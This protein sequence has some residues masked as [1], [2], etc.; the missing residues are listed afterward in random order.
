MNLFEA[1][2]QASDTPGSVD[3]PSAAQLDRDDPLRPRRKAF[4][5]PDG[6]IYLDGNSLGPMT[7]AARQR[8]HDVVEQQWG[9]GLITSWNR[10]AWI[11]L[12][13]TVGEKI[14]PLLGAGTGQVICCDSISVNLFKLLSAALRLNPGRRKVLSQRD[15]FPTD[16]YVGQG[17]QELLGTQRC[18]LVT[19]DEGDIESAL[20]Q[21]VAVLMLSQVNFR[22]GY[23]H[24][25]QRLTE[26][27]HARG[28]LVIWDLAHSAGIMPLELDR[29]QV[30]FAVGCGYKYLN[31][32]PGAPAFIYAARRHQHALQQPLAGWMGH[33]APFSF[34]PEYE[35]ANDIKQ[36][37]AGTPPVLS[38]SVLDAALETYRELPVEL[39]REKSL[40]LADYFAI[41]V[42]QCREQDSLRR[43]TP[44]DH[45]QRGGQ[46]A[47]T[48]EHAYAIC[49]ALIAAGV[50]ADF[51][52]PNI[53]R[54][55][56]SPLYLSYTEMD[57]AVVRLLAIMRRGT[58]RRP[59]Y[60]RKEKVT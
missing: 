12:P 42:L 14:A 46:L 24:D 18:E 25:I 20:D 15:N 55:G 5:L 31:G 38:M 10:H 60:N 32:G 49:Q 48:H 47:Y 56:F 17:L 39:V 59:E 3:L 16:L 27:A 13:E 22:S 58:Y 52:A 11:D 7:A 8:A 45:R 30:D 54:F 41:R 26:L 1:L 6:V 33:R 35:A 21:D 2:V 51:R 9:Q 40:A 34:A 23:A 28:I 43:I 44:L 53:L 57:T 36:F 29:W 50:V 19:V 4:V 37:L